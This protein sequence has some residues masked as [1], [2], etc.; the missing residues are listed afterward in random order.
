MEVI[1]LGV[2]IGHASID[3]RGKARG[4]QAGDQTGREVCTR[5][6]YNKGWNKLIRPK[7]SDVAE[8]I[9]RA[10]E[11]AC[12]NNN[13]GY[14]QLQRTT[15]FEAAK[16]QKWDLSKIK[17][18]VETDC[19]A[20]V[21]VCVNAAGISVSGSMYTGNEASVLKA[22]GKFEVYTDS[23]H[24]VSDKYLMRGDILLKEGSHTAI[25]LSDGAE[26]H[27][28]RKDGSLSGTYEVT[29]SS[30][31]IRWKPIDGEVMH[32]APKG[33]R[34]EC[35]GQYMDV[36]GSKW[37]LVKCDRVK[38]WASSKYLKKVK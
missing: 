4:G 11:Q 26:T 8:K 18:K 33:S 3:E 15:L 35:D 1:D 5:E 27:Q 34:V 9:A 6:W 24:L 17:T 37:L 12:A 29:A 23:K 13:I 31:N 25:V 7:N 20:L 38:G 36:Y 2:K 21:A 32:K 30:L 19:S 10:M 28:K 22:T 16:K 14:D